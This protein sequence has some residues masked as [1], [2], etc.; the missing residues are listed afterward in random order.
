MTRAN[1]EPLRIRTARSYPVPF[2]IDLGQRNAVFVKRPLTPLRRFFDCA[3]AFGFYPE[4]DYDALH[5]INAVPLLGRSPYIIT[6]EDYLP[7]VPEDRYIGWLERYLQ[8]RLLDPKCRALIAISEFGL[9]QFRWQNRDFAERA[10]LEAKMHLIY[11]AMRLRRTTPKTRSG[12]LKLLFVAHH[13]LLKGGPALIRAHERLRKAGVPVETTIVTSL[14]YDQ[15]DYFGPPSRELMERETA[16]LGT[17]E[18]VTHHR[19]LPNAE[20]LRLMDEADFFIFPTFQDTF[21]F[22]PVEA[23]AHATPVLATNTCAQPEIVEDGVNGYLL[24]F[25]NDEQVGKWKWLY[26]TK[27]PGYVEAY[28]QA[29]ERIAET[30]YTRLHASVEAQPSDYEAL[31]AGAIR[32]MQ[33][34]FNIDKARERLEALYELL[35]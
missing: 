20:V 9:R 2:L 24:P 11:P 29:I 14:R 13:F 35:R 7:R 6:F 16:K 25:E 1:N 27:E 30:M 32:Q 15:H 28:E 10:A 8:Q 19:L 21:G 23:L 5:T 3:D 4:P 26:R 22:A 33:T 18:G 12:K 34:R 31:S 17:T